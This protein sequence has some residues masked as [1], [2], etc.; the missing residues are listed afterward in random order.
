MIREASD[1]SRIPFSTEVRDMTGRRRDANKI[2]LQL[3]EVDSAGELFLAS[4]EPVT[5][6]LSSSP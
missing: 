2:D 1:D 6:G 4:L 3:V 5:G